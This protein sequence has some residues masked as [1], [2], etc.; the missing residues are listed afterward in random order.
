M[1]PLRNR[2]ERQIAAAGEGIAANNSQAARK[3][4]AVQIRAV[5]KSTFAQVVQAFRE[6]QRILKRTVGKST[7]TNARQSFRENKRRNSGTI[8]GIIANGIQAPGKIDVG[9]TSVR[10]RIFSN[11]GQAHGKR[12]VGKIAA[13]TEC[14]ITDG[15]YA[16]FDKHIGNDF[17]I[18]VPRRGTVVK[19]I[20]VAGAGDSQCTNS[21]QRP[22]QVVAAGAAVNNDFRSRLA[23][24][25]A[26]ITGNAV[27]RGRNFGI[28]IAVAALGT[29]VGSVTIHRTSGSC[30]NGFILV[31]TLHL[32]TFGGNLALGNIQHKGHV[33]GLLHRNNR[34]Y[35]RRI[36]SGP[37]SNNGLILVLTGL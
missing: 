11:I 21:G 3:I 14:I 1:D 10:E 9:Q 15:R 33:A 4:D 28:G 2:N 12:N 8:E 17:G 24:V 29:G 35:P 7:F 25:D 34:I 20:H 18:V 19:T 30:N 37:I 6:S 36:R 5:G 23:A 16:V 32:L 27:A 22:G 13:L 26:G 31:L